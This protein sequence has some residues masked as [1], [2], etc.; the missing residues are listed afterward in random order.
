MEAFGPQR[1]IKPSLPGEIHTAAFRHPGLC[2][3]TPHFLFVLLSFSCVYVTKQL[4]QKVI[5][6]CDLH[7]QVNIQVLLLSRVLSPEI[8]FSIPF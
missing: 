4:G 6:F 5:K 3:W 2:F 8:F 7:S 1:S